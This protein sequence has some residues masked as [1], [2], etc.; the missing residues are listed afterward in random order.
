[1]WIGKKKR[2]FRQ[3]DIPDWMRVDILG[4]QV[5]TKSTTWDLEQALHYQ[6]GG[7]PEHF[8]ARSTGV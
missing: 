6:L 1:M 8:G 7:S 2:H 5:H 4:A 3:G